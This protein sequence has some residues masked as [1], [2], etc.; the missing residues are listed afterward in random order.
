MKIRNRRQTIL[1]GATVA[2]LVL[3]ACGSEVPPKEFVN[4][5]DVG[6][7]GNGNAAVGGDG[8]GAG[9][10]AVGNGSA[11]GSLGGS[12]SGSSGSGAGSSGGGSGSGAGSTTGGGANSRGGSGTGGTSRRG[13]TSGGTGSGGGN[14]VAGIKAASCAGFRNG[15]GITNSTITIANA[16]DLSGPVPGLFKSAQAA[17]TAFV[18]YFN[19]TSSICGR[20][21]K[22]TG[23]DSAT[24]ESGDQQAATTACSSAFALVGSMSAFD[25]GGASTVTG[26]GIPDLRSTSTETARFKSPVTF[27]AYSLAVNEIPSFPFNYFKQIAK[28]GEKNAG[29]VYL[30]AGA[31][32]LNANSFMAAES[33]LGYNFKDKIAIDVTA[34]PNYNGYATQLKGDGIKYVQYVGAYQYAQ[35]LKSAF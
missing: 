22:L 21:L 1:L 15:P 25:A 27:G 17:V 8:T 6:G 33:K 24:S 19:S 26:C 34:V 4:A 11:A 23:L 28:G 30:N 7:T 14:A 20:K 32:S 31:A 29:F 3:A 13:S 10:D 35:K 9:G 2:C 16:A 18:A 12:G 5:Q